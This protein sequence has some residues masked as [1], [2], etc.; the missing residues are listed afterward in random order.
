MIWAIVWPR[1]LYQGLPRGQTTAKPMDGPHVT[2][3]QSPMY[4]VGMLFRLH[5]ETANVWTHLVPYVAQ[6][7]FIVQV[8]IVGNPTWAGFDRVPVAQLRTADH[9][10]LTALVLVNSFVCLFSAACH[11]WYAKSRDWFHA[12]VFLDRL[13][14]STSAV[15]AGTILTWASTA[16]RT[17]AWQ[18]GTAAAQAAAFLASVALL[19]RFNRAR[20]EKMWYTALVVIAT[21]SW[22]LAFSQSHSGSISHEDHPLLAAGSQSMVTAATCVVCGLFFFFARL[23]ERLA[24]PGTFDLIGHSHQIWHLWVAVAMFYV[25][26]GASQLAHGL[27]GILES[28]PS[29]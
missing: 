15:S 9:V 28:C 3:Y 18:Y 19:F 5:S 7:Y 2:P 12:M 11:M 23:P 6:Q 22:T 29:P 20:Y 8:L 21:F 27:P 1:W 13:G 25:L 4:Y 24:P 26:R 14:I 17:P 10:L 16:C